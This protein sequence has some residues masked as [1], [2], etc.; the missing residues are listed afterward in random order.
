VSAPADG[1]RVTGA[2][3]GDAPEPGRWLNRTVLGASLTSGLADMAYQ[4]ASVVLP[5]FMAA[6]GIPPTAL[7]VLEGVADATASFT[8]MGS[9]YLSDRLGIRKSLA[10]FGYL[11]TLVS[12]AMMAVAGGLALLASG[13]ILGWL[14]R[15]IRSPLRAAIMAE[16]VTPETRGRAFGFHRMADTIGA[17]VGPLIGVLLLGAWSPPSAAELQAG[18]LLD[19]TAPFRLVLWFTLVPAGLAVLSFAFLVRDGRRRPNKHIQFWSSLRGWSPAFRRYLVGVGSFGIGDFAHT[20]LVLAATQMLTP[21]HGVVGAAQIAGFLYIA[22]NLVS[23][24]VA[25]PVGVLA[26]R[27]GHQRV[28]VMGYGIG[29]A[30]AA[31]T[32]FAFASGL[33]SIALLALIFA[34]AGTYAAVQESL[35]DVLTA[36]LVP[37]PTR[38]LAFGVLGSVNGVGDFVSSTTLGLVWAAA[39]PEAAFALAAVMMAVGTL[40]MSRPLHVS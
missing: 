24:V 17:V 28:L 21:T 25:F 14:G 37:A 23:A 8:K 32:A 18:A 2:T 38:A 15:G 36:E 9:G 10:V 11:L 16:A 35:E 19:L 31:L 22:R 7:G 30:T 6:L 27:I 39:S 26:D 3:D 13:R 34:L 33:D 4:T 40:V 20:M 1:G 29:V 12:Q 5:G